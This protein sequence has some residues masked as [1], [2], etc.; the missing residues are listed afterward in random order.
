MPL[1]DFVDQEFVEISHSKVNMGHNPLTSDL[2][3]QN[4][5]S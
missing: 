3:N 5:S 4:K 2:Q 1:V